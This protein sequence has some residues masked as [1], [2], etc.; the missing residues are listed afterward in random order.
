MTMVSAAVSD[1]REMMVT[2]EHCVS[3][4]DEDARYRLLLSIIGS[5]V[6]RQSLL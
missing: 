4:D 5:S 1:A 6:S 3:T 2:G